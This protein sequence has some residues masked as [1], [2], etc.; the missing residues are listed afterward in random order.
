MPLQAPEKS[1]VGP[2]VFNNFCYWHGGSTY[3]PKEPSN[4]PILELIKG[5][6]NMGKLTEL[7]L[8]VEWANRDKG[9]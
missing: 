3:R 1:Q 8:A 5:N 7:K 2:H 9:E 6:S 4:N